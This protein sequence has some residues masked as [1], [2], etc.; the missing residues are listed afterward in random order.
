M[1]LLYDTVD[2]VVAHAMHIG[3]ARMQA[4]ASEV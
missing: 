2:V 3:E 4:I 1:A